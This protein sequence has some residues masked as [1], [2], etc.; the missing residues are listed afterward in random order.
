M[1]KHLAI[2]SFILLTLALCVPSLFAQA[3]GTI[4]GVCK[5]IQ[6]NPIADG[7]VQLVNIDS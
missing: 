3:A 1:K 7:V 2:F 4:K 6:G 5:D